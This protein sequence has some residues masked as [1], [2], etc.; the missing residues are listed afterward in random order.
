M[1]ELREVFEMTTKQAEPELDSWRDQEHRQQ[2]AHRRRRIGAFAVAAA[3]GVAAV[4][5]LWTMRPAQDAT[6]P[7]NE[8]P[9]VNP[10]GASPVDIATGFV[11]A[12]GGF[13]AERAIAYLAEG[14]DVS[15]VGGAYGAG[16]SPEEWPLNLS[17]W[18]ATGYRQILD[19][20]EE[21]GSSAAG[22]QVRCT[23]AYHNLGSE[24]IGRGPF[25]GSYW[26]VTVLDGQIVSGSQNCEIEKFSPQM[27]EPFAEWVSTT[28]PKDAA[29]MYTSGLDD[30]I[31]TRESIRLWGTHTKEYVKEVQRGNAQ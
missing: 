7:A 11:E 26:D 9:A 8:A 30:Y 21:T 24:R 28:Y 31:L 19:S 14:A 2:R 20:C 29:V 10:L 4:V 22:T 27:W 16:G 17:W 25:S 15:V 5:L 1:A 6:T 18:H 23:L 3:I 12:Y 13:D